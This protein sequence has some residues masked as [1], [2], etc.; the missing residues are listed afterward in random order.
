MTTRVINIKSKESYHVYIGNRI[1]F[2]PQ[3]YPQAMWSKRKIEGSN[4]RKKGIT[5]A[6]SIEVHN[7]YQLSITINTDILYLMNF[8]LFTRKSKCGRCGKKFWTETGL[9]VHNLS[10]HV[11]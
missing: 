5:T 9:A 4:E 6:E 10:T 11:S 3:K 1:R 7:H 2:H 8:V